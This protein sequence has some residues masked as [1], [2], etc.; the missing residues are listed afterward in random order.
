MYLSF[1]RYPGFLVACAAG[2]IALAA[3]PSQA[4]PQSFAATGVGQIPDSLSC[5][6]AGVPLVLSFNVTGVGAPLTDVRVSLNFAPAH[7]FVGD[8]T[9]TLRPP[10]GSPSVVLFSRVGSTSA[11]SAG[12]GA[13]VDGAYTFVDP[14]VST[15]NIWIPAYGGVLV[16]SGT[17]AV[18]LPGPVVTTPAGTAPLTSVFAGLN[19]AQINGTWTLNITDRCIGDVGGVSQATLQLDSSPPAQEFTVNPPQLNFGVV[20]V[21][22]LTLRAFR[23]TAAASNTQNID[24][25][26]ANCSIGGADAGQFARLFSNVTLAPGASVQLPM[27]FRPTSLGNKTALLTC[28]GVL[29]SGVTPTTLAVSLVGVAGIPEPPPN[30][31]DVDGDGVMNPLTDGLFMLR[32]QLGIAPATA[33]NGIVLNAP[34]NTPLKAALLMAQRCGFHVPD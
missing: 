30:C 32:L 19:A 4:V 22:E 5:G 10:A 14:S 6:A 11:N 2:L 25:T 31:Y 1:R 20:D 28:T 23:V 15:A 7:T 26:A 34:R 12:S 33:A 21:N 8:L 16:P 9:A 13:S 3:A 29:P 24:I 17:Y 27:A 18:T